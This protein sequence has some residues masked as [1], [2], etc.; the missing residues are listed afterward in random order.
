MSQKHKYD[1]EAVT[2]IAHVYLSHKSEALHRRNKR[3]RW[4][5][6]DINWSV[7][8]LVFGKA[9]FGLFTLFPLLQCLSEVHADCTTTR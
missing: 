7:I 8:P 9:L 6:T 3:K 5:Q 2:P 4:M 1:A